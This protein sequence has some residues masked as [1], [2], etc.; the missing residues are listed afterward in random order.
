MFPR[1]MTLHRIN[2]G[3]VVVVFCFVAIATLTSGCA[4]SGDEDKQI[5]ASGGFSVDAP[6]RVDSQPPLPDGPVI[7]DAPVGGDTDGGSGSL[8]CQSHDE[9]GAG[10][11]CAGLDVLPVTSCI[12]GTIV[13]VLNTCLPIP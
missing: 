1:V 7:T 8:N 4:S 11:C 10:R 12:D 6:Q 2:I 3:L 13:P 9:C 5:D